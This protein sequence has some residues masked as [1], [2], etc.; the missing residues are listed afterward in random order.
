MGLLRS[1]LK[2]GTLVL[3]V[4]DARRYIDKMG[5]VTNIQFDDMNGGKEGHN[6][7]RPYKKYVQRID[8]MERIIRFMLEELNR[9]DCK[10]TTQKVNEFLEGAET[11]KLDDVEG[12]LQQLYKQFVEFKER[13]AFIQGQRNQSVEGQQV[14]AA[15]IRIMGGVAGASSQGGGLEKPLLSDDRKVD[16]IAGVVP[17]VDQAR[18]V[19]AL[20]RASR[21][22]AFTQVNPIAESVFDPKTGAKVEKSVFVIYFQAASGGAQD[23]K[24]LS[25]KF[26]KAGGEKFAPFNVRRLI[27]E[28]SE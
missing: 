1:E 9:F 22:N 23:V 10:L 24:G 2:H 20:W 11:Y 15:A 3:P 16:Y 17:K 4:Q 28:A 5:A 26:Y 13:D 7:R 18:F 12:D 14:V 19:R 25:M 8:E 27:Q 6:F 21:G